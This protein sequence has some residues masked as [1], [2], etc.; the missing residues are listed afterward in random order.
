M[1]A[2]HVVVPEDKKYQA[3]K[4]LK[5]IYSSIPRQNY[6]EGIQWRAIENIVD[7]FFIETEQSDIVVE[8]IKFK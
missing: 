2:I 7:R 6:S 1:S 5:E 4:A 3:R 8:R